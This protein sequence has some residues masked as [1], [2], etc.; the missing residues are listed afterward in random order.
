MQVGVGRI[1]AI[2]GK[3]L[4]GRLNRT[5]QN[6]LVVPDQP[7]LDGINA[8]RGFIRQFVA[9]PLGMG[10][11][12]EG[13]VT[14][15]E[16]FGGLQLRVHDP[17]PGR[18][19]ER[20][21]KRRYDRLMEPMSMMPALPVMEMG[22]GAGGKMRQKVY[23]DEYGVDTWDL[24]NYGE[25]YVHIANSMTFREITGHEPPETP[26]SARSYTECGL[27]WFELYD[28]E[29]GD[30][31]PSGKL[32]KVKSVKQMDKKKGFGPQQDDGAVAV[33]KG[34]V[35]KLKVAPK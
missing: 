31:A 34:Q 18:F 3:R 16:E 20:E 29:K 2:T 5:S 19:P 8:G 6:Y 9:M 33:G 7:W 26:V 28:E 4:H 11:T 32:A 14:G 30:V 35:K 17:K 22:L 15:K 13:R 10:Y 25:V 21:P 24:E 23:P 27:P 1:N 12:V